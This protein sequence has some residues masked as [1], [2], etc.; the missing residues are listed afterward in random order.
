MRNKV[1]ALFRKRF[2]LYFVRQCTHKNNRGTFTY[3]Q[4]RAGPEKK[5]YTGVV[6]YVPR[7][8]VYGKRKVNTVLSSTKTLLPGPGQ[9]GHTERKK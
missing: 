9:R 7:A 3:K 4:K 6:A 1:V 2:N 5:F 8:L